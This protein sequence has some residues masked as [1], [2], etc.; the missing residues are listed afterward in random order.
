MFAN[1][2]VTNESNF[3]VARVGC[4]SMGHTVDLKNKKFV[5][6]CKIL[7]NYHCKNNE[8]YFQNC[9]KVHGKID[10]SK[11]HYLK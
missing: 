7:S 11:E 4:S 5:M 1:A 6:F 10:P 8:C 2:N 3:D 9:P